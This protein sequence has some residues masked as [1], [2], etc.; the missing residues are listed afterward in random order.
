MFVV[1]AHGVGLDV[2]A[3]VEPEHIVA[4]IPGYDVQT[5]SGRIFAT[6]F[7]LK[8]IQDQKYDSEAMN[9]FDPDHPYHEVGDFGIL[10]E[11]YQTIAN[12]ARDNKQPDQATIGAL[13][14]VFFDPTMPCAGHDVKVFLNDWFNAATTRND[15]TTAAAIAQLY[16]QMAREPDAANEM[17]TCVV[18]LKKQLA[19]H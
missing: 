12:R 14:E 3:V 19:K 8:D 16:R 6:N 2:G 17:D 11:L 7:R 15:V 1:V 5:T 13:K 10:L 9:K 18:N 4:R